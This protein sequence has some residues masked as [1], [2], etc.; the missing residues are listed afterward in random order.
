MAV[1]IWI[2]DDDQD[3]R[4]LLADL[5]RYYRFS[6]NTDSLK[7]FQEQPAYFSEILRNCSPD[8]LII[9]VPFPYLSN[10]IWIKNNLV[11][12]MTGQKL[13][14]I[15]TNPLLQKTVS[16]YPI[17]VKPPSKDAFLDQIRRLLPP[18][19]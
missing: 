13:I 17:I 9:D 10:W 8:L 2:I 6:V 1:S 16:A 4:E 19:P 7:I 3:N 5:L 12:K 18:R 15:T 14:L 11:N